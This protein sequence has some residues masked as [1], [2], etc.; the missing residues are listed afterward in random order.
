[1]EAQTATTP[2]AAATGSKTLADLLPLAVEKH[3]DKVAQK[4]KDQSKGEWVDVSYPELGEIAKEVTLGLQELGIDRGDKV[5]ILSNTRPEWTYADFGILATGATVV[6]IYQTNSPEECHYVLE[7]SESVAVILE[8]QDQL[9]KIRKVRDDLPNLRHVISMEPLDGD[10]VMSLD[11]LREKGRGRSDEDYKQR[12]ASVR[13]LRRRH[14][15]LHV[16]HHRPAQ[17]LRD[18][19]PELARHARHGADAERADGGR[20]GLPLPAAGARVRAADPARLARRGR[21][22]RLLGARRSE[23]H[24]EPDGG[25]ADLLPVGASHV[26]EDLLDGDLGRARQGAARAGRRSWA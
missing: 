6:P 25:E 5:G 19:P 4:Y 8:D 9:D 1:M 14:L 11:E 22:D 16:R 23:D 3:A 2:S 18:R 13:G 20:G 21:D 12:I 7:H 17:G 26:R 10:D 24:P 15:H